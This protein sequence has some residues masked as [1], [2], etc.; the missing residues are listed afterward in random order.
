M[1]PP[2]FIA[3]DGTQMNTDIGVIFA[4]VCGFC[5]AHQAVSFI[6]LIEQDFMNS[7]AKSK[8]FDQEIV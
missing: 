5:F 7:G 4:G 1:R 6:V 2:F 8:P 3:T